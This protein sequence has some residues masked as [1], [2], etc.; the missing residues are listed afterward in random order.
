MSVRT[1]LGFFRKIQHKM[2]M[3][4]V[5]S[6]ASMYLGVASVSVWKCTGDTNTMLPKRM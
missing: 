6:A 4:G 5:P 2:S 3:K 1:G